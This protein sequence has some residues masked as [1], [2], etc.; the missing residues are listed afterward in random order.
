MPKNILL[1]YQLKE[2]GTIIT[3]TTPSTKENSFWGGNIPFVTPADLKE[4]RY[5]KTTERTLTEKGAQKGRLLPKDSVLVTCIGATI[6]K[7]AMAIEPCLTNQQINAIICRPEHDPTCVYYALSFAMEYLKLVADVNVLPIIK[8]STFGK[9]KIKLPPSKEQEAISRIFDSVDKTIECVQEATAR[10]KTVKKALV[11][12]FFEKGLRKEKQRKTQLGFIPNSWEVV[13]VKFVVNQFQYGLSVAMS[14]KGQFPILR[15]GNIQ[16]GEVLF[17]DLK[18][19]NLPENIAKVYLLNRGDL[20]FNRTNS[21]EHVGKVGIYRSDNQAVFASYL[22]RLLTDPSK[23]DNYYL[24]Q[25]LSSY[26]TQ[27][28]IKRYATP[29]VQQVNVNAKNLGRILIPLPVGK[30]GLKEQKEIAVILEK[31]DENI[32]NYEPVLRSLNQLKRSLMHDLLTGK[33]RVKDLNL[34]SMVNP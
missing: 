14:S 2:L 27:C 23:V 26:P 22:I 8:K 31:A 21:Q 9:L 10:A 25:L 20:L 4:R 3:G 16:E 28:R 19:I 32:R 5:I 24:G 7:M 18:Y 13:P 12:T 33:A 15:M 29:G 1:P 17:N 34:K 6:G 30:D 11:Q